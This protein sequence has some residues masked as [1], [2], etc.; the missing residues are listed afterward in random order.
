M[1]L[2]K[3]IL[4][5]HSNLSRNQVQKFISNG[6]IR[7]NGKIVK[8]SHN[9]KPEEEELE[10]NKIDVV[11]R[12]LIAENIELEII[13]ETDDYL[14]IN[15]PV[16]MVVHPGDSDS[17]LTGTV[18]NAVKDMVEEGA[19]SDP[20]R[21]GIVHRLDKDTSGLLL[22]AKTKEAYDFFVK[23]F[24]DRQVYK[25]YLTLVAGEL[26]A[27]EGVIE[28]PIRRDDANR[29]KMMVARDGKEAISVFHLQE[30]FSL[31]PERIVNLMQVEIKTGRTH[32]IR[33]HFSAIET[34]VI[35]DSVYGS[36]SYNKLFSEKWHLNSQFLHAWRLRIA[37]IENN[38]RFA[39]DAEAPLPR[40]LEDILTKLRRVG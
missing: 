29:K 28:S 24:S 32:Q 23:K 35:G 20:M 25:A 9:F 27:K 10:I 14:L 18:A 26:P 38:G 4:E 22:I 2:D 19:W 12:E 40:K 30:R 13:K 39:I 37:D 5:K 7:V 17:H 21:P 15:K 36:R 6:D 16:G 11:E 1:R 34:P 8:P 3:Y 33:V 31:S